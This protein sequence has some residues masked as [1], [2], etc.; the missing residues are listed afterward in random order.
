MVDKLIVFSL[1]TFLAGCTSI[2]ESL[3]V[4]KAV[5]LNQEILEAESLGRTLYDDI[6]SDDG[7]APNTSREADLIRMVEEKGI[8]C[9]GTY[10]AVST[11]NDEKGEENLF[12]VLFPDSEGVQFGRHFRFRF[13]AGTNDII[14]VVPSTRS[15][16]LVPAAGETVPFATHLLSEVPNEF[17][18]FLSLIH[19]KEIYVSTSKGLW[20][21]ENGKISPVEK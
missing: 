12:L 17:H 15:C 3:A 9:E 6:I 2:T 13:K 8:G 7:S 5:N 16:L 1:A 11:F 4:S 18:V 10:K 21:V 14:D 19:N 20:N